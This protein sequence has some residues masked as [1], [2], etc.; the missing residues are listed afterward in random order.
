MSDFRKRRLVFLLAAVLALASLLALSSSAS[1]DSIVSSNK[2]KAQRILAEL[3]R[4]D[5]ELGRIV[6]RYDKVN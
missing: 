3:D 1:A 6:E 2:A 5:S 4:M